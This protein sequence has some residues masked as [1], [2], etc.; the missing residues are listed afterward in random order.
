[1]RSN[2]EAPVVARSAHQQVHQEASLDEVNRLISH[3]D[4]GNN[5]IEGDGAEENP[6]DQS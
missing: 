4:H 3:V 2:L 5:E 1:M 6:G